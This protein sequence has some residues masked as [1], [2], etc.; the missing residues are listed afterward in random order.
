MFEEF[1]KSVSF[2][3]CS[4]NQQ[5]MQNLDLSGYWKILDINKLCKIAFD[6]IRK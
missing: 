6:K 3:I 5:V 1:T 2:N 4:K